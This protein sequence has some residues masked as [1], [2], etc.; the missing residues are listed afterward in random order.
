MFNRTG[1]YRYTDHLMAYES[2][3]PQWD[4]IDPHLLPITTPL[5]V[6]I[7]EQC[8]ASHP[9]KQF[10]Q[11]IVQGLHKG[12]RIGFDASRN[13]PSTSEQHDI[14]SKYLQEEIA[15]GRILGPFTPGE[16]NTPIHISPIGVIPKRHQPNKWRLIVDMSS[17]DGFSINDGIN[18]ELSSLTYIKIQDVIQQILQLGPGAELAKIDIKSAYCI[19]PINPADRH[20]L[21]MAWDGKINIEACLPFGLRSAPKI[22][23]AVADALAWIILEHGASLLGHY[24][25]DFVTMGPAGQGTCRANLQ[26]VLALCEL[27]GVPLA[28]EKSMGPCTCLDYIGFLLDTIAMEVRLPKEKLARLVYAI[29]AWKYKKYCTKH[30]LESLIGQLQHASA[31]VRPGRSFLRR[32]II[33]AKSKSQPSHPLRLNTSFRADLAW[34]ALF[35]EQWNGISMMSAVGT[36]MPAHTLVS[37]AS[38][39]W[40][41]GAFTDSAWFQVQWQTSSADYP[42][43]TKELIP[44]ILAAIAWGKTWQG[45]TILARCDNAAVVAVINSRYS[46][47]EQLMHLLRCLFFTEAKFQIQIIAEHIPGHQN[48][49]AD[50]LS[51]DRASSFL[52][53]AP[54]MDPRPTPIPPDLI[55]ALMASPPNWLFPNW[56]ASWGSIL[57][58]V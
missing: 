19:I 15:E 55:P 51:R 53:K 36:H 22:F 10:A 29:R 47:D 23:S 27:L 50:D 8:L 13:M 44:I 30:E 43:A 54:Y 4:H 9:D 1:L 28:S 58:R 20:L 35:L 26:I 31:V 11:Y 25:D 7:W 40:G 5:H 16:L 56:T 52:S 49:L 41:C 57:S 42:I 6:G 2:L 32:M 17:P 12:F 18:T 48:V 45:S 46:R 34:W 21:G 14:V 39:H 37:D 33:L 3:P 24:L 38:G